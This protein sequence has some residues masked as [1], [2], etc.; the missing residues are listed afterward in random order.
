M[1]KWK[2][3]FCFCFYFSPFFSNVFTLLFWNFLK[4]ALVRKEKKKKNNK[5]SNALC[6]HDSKKYCNE[7]Y[8]FPFSLPSCSPFPYLFP[9]LF[10][11]LSSLSLS[12]PSSSLFPLLFPFFVSVHVFPINLGFALVTVVAKCFDSSPAAAC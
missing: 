10:C 7:Y 3:G 12:F 9:L 5:N 11:P 2:S 4:K 1:T 6:C 8:P